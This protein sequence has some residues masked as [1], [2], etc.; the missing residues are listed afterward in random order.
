MTAL[1]RNQN[2]FRVPY[3]NNQIIVIYINL[4]CTLNCP[5]DIAL[6][7]ILYYLNEIKKKIGLNWE[8]EQYPVHFVC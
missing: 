7:I 2:F 5:C 1:L 6:I 8:V 3:T 4:S